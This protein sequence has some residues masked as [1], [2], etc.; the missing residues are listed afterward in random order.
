MSLRYLKE[1]NQ[2]P[3]SADRQEHEEPSE[4]EAERLQ[5]TYHHLPSAQQQQHLLTATSLRQHHDSV[6]PGASFD[7]QRRKQTWQ[8]RRRLPHQTARCPTTTDSCW[9]AT[10]EH[11]PGDKRRSRHALE[12]R[13][14][15]RR[16]RVR[17]RVRKER[18]LFSVLMKTV[19]TNTHRCLLKL[20]SFT[21][22]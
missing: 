16:Q 4:G 21:E 1:Q 5:L 7:R 17:L 18:S 6:V 20:D 2:L 13:D 11:L 14:G 8:P 3:S 9:A 10:S 22:L 19:E 12:V 15:Q